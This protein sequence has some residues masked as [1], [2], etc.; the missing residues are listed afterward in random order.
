MLYT[1]ENLCR[2]T[3]LRSY[4]DEAGYIPILFVCNFISSFGVNYP[5]VVELLKS[6]EVLEVDNANETIRLKNKWEMV[7]IIV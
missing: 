3:F 4:M 2:D 7:N 6:S 5:D 1:V